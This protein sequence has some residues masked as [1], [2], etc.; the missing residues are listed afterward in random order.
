MNSIDRNGTLIPS[1]W[2]G[3][4]S[5]QDGRPWKEI[6]FFSFSDEFQSSLRSSTSVPFLYT[7]LTFNFYLV[8]FWKH[9]QP[10]KKGSDEILLDKFYIVKNLKGFKLIVWLKKIAKLFK[11]GKLTVQRGRALRNGFFRF[12]LSLVIY[13]R[14]KR[15]L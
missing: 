2:P 13:F 15:N 8:Q 7:N 10:C 6:L 3:K 11:D 5:S 9:S 4:K 1:H 14:E 12:L